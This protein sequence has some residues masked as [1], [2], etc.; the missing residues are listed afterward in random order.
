MTQKENKIFN[1]KEKLNKLILEGN[2]LKS[3][4]VVSFPIIV[5]NIF[6][7]LFSNIDSLFSIG[8]PNSSEMGNFIQISK[9][10]QA[11]IDSIGVSLGIAG[12][13]LMVS[14][15]AKTKDIYNPKARQIASL[16]FVLL[17]S[18]SVL[19]FFIMFLM[20]PVVCNIIGLKG[21]LIKNFISAF[22]LKMLGVILLAINVFFLGTERISGK[23]KKVLI[24]NCIMMGLKIGLSFLIFHGLG[25]KTALGL[26]IASVLAHGS[27][28]IVAFFTL[29]N[30]KNPFC[31]NIRDFSWKNV[32]KNKKIIKTIFKFGFTLM[33]GKILYEFGRLLTLYMIKS[34]TNAPFLGFQGFGEGTLKNMG[35]ADGAINLFVQI[36]FSLK[37]G[38][39]MIVSENLGNKNPKRAIKTLIITSISAFLIFG[40]T[41]LICAP[42]KYKGLGYG[43]QIY[44]FFKNLGKN[45]NDIDKTIPPGFSEFLIG[46]ILTTGLI[47]TQLEVISTFLIASKQP[48]YDLFLN[49]GRVFLFRIPFLYLF[50]HYWLKPGHT[51]EYHVYSFANFSS[52]LIM[53]IFMLFLCLRVIFKMK[54]RDIAITKK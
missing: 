48:K 52:N 49:F 31:L 45:G 7:V 1:K 43:D 22:R 40:L 47:T 4:L 51:W 26:E 41:Y 29:L 21:D 11:I 25:C 15:I 42:T 23:I 44:L 20:A 16:T 12:V 6:K 18:I 28:T 8:S 14:E 17:I 46:A 9:S 3:L 10:I 36:A 35:V 13:T 2:L 30:K 32:L 27:I 24:L 37:E 39:L 38:E 19:L 5:F 54:K 50:R 53:L 34:S 33:L